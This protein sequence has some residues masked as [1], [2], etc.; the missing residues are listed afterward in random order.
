MKIVFLS[1]YSG[2]NKRG[3]ETFVHEL[4]NRLSDFGNDVIVYQG[5]EELQDSSYEV[6][7]LLNASSIPDFDDSVDVVIPM[8]GRFQALKS[9]IWCKTK[10]KKIIIIGQSGLGFDDKFNLFLFP[11]CFISLTKFQ[12]RW[13]KRVN[14]LVFHKTI[15]N[16]VDLNK[17]KID[18]HK[19][20]NKIKHVLSVGALEKSKRHELTIEAV[21]ILNNAKLTILGEG[22]EKNTLLQLG[23]KMMPGRFEIKSIPHS[24]IYEYFSKSDLLVFS[25]IPQESFGIVIV[26]A[27][28]SN[29][30]VVANNDPIRREIIGDAGLFVDP[31]DINKFSNIISLALEKDWD[32]IP[33]RQSLQ[34]DWKTISSEYNNL[35]KNI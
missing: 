14:P 19:K 23:E 22:E 12:E 35:I 15:P 26:E 7:K 34:Y 1:Y 4:G 5:G 27:L 21:S 9:S 30:P 2:I 25:S 31:R 18:R 6:R 32:E 11:N 16:G 28:A 13:A 24:E 33:N 8:N 20:I 17:F 29:L 3:V 10:Q